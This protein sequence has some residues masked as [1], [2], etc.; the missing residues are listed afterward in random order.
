MILTIMKWAVCPVALADG[1][2]WLTPEGTGPELEEEPS[3]GIEWVTPEEE[4]S[5]IGGQEQAELAEPAEQ[6]EP[7]ESETEWLEPEPEPEQEPET[8]VEP[9][10]EMEPVETGMI[11]VTVPATG[12]IIINPYRLP[13]EQGGETVRDQIANG[14]QILTS[15]SREPL[16]VNAAITV[17]TEEGGGLKITD[18]PIGT[19]EREK[20][21]YVY[22]EFHNV[23]D[24]N[25]EAEWSESYTGAPNQ[26]LAKEGGAAG[27]VLRLEAAGDEAPTYAAYRLFGMLSEHPETGWHTGDKLSVTVSF[28]FRPVEEAA[29]EPEQVEETV[30]PE[31]KEEA[32]EPEPMMEAVEPEPIEEAVEPEPM[33][34]VVEPEPV[35]IELEEKQ[36]EGIRSYANEAEPDWMLPPGSETGEG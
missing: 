18:Q 35:E 36:E 6:V 23:T 20:L 14:G 7:E 31:P 24:A 26:L 9:E 16:I 34:E 27:E 8:E 30:E 29:S 25:S 32:V 33:E 3:A 11:D 19:D 28:T 5:H 15:R 17:N 1:I 22:A 2:D 10:T 13:V 12:E 21:A 4:M